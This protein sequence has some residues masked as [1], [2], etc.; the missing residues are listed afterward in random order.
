MKEVIGSQ[1]EWNPGLRSSSGAEG[2]R[3]DIA[4]WHKSS[5][6]LNQSCVV[7]Q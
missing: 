3:S 1:E 4:M 6:T 7:S 5:S 2:V